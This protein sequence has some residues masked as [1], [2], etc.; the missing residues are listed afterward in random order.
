MTD[1]VIVAA[2]RTPVGSFNG[3][4][5]RTSGAALG[6][7]AIRE[8]LKR[9]KVEPGEVS[10]VI[11]GQILTAAQ[12]MNAARQASI[13][14][15]LPK[16]VP[17]WTVNQVCGSG[18]RSVALGAQAI[19]SGDSAIVVAGG[20]ES[21]SQCA[22]RACICARAPRWA[23]RDDRHDDQ[24]RAVGRLQRLSHGQYRRERGAPAGRSRAR[25]RTSSPPARRTRPRPPLKSGRF[26]DEIVPV[27]IMVKKGEAWSTPTSIRAP[28][29]PRRCWPS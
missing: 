5:G 13:H 17:A 4:A 9:A 1:V 24:G 19:M 7:V 11:M 23:M 8:A 6:E 27:K 28:A 20:Q 12:G 18:L 25:T 3:S 16:E 15:G 26:K 21:M 22:A 29:P 10:E 14:A 2:A